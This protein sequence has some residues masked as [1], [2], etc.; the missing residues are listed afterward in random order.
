[1]PGPGTIL[2]QTLGRIGL[3]PKPGCA[4]I[5]HMKEMDRR[6]PDWCK[7]NQKLIVSWMHE[8]AKRRHLPFNNAVASALVSR[9]IRRS[10][11]GPISRSATLTPTTPPKRITQK[12]LSPKKSGLKKMAIRWTYGVTTV[13]ERFGEV[14][15]RTLNSLAN[16]GFDKP[17]LFVDGL[18]HEAHCR[19]TFGLEATL[20]FPR[21]H[22]A[23]NWVLAAYELY[24]RNPVSHFYAIFQDDILASQGL[25]EYL[26]Q[27]KYPRLGYWNLFTSPENQALAP[28][29]KNGAWYLSNQLGKGA[30]GLVFDRN[31]LV[32]LLASRHM[33]M[34]PQ[35]PGRGSRAIDGGVVTAL[36]NAN[37][38]EYVHTPSLLQHQDGPS[39]IHHGKYAKA[40]TFQ[41]ENFDLTSLIQSEQKQ[42]G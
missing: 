14:L 33:V 35:T 8:E 10:R 28:K 19:E 40:P 15:P 5:Q 25:R 30:L 20:R 16:A 2:H 37:I 34:R 41:G 12:S 24:I 27:C 11:N 29:G 22:T 38:R 6:G 7:K 36:Q 4:C 31:A 26:A 3:R 39:M 21:I 9:A 23:G 18:E 13:P 32:S 42:P 17:R 1:M